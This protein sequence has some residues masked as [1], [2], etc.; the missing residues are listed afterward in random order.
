M[1]AGAEIQPR[2][3][4]QM[5]ATPMSS[6]SDPNTAT[7]GTGQTSNPYNA[8]TNPYIQAAQANTMGNLYGAR[9]AT[10]ANRIN[11]NTP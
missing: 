9:A 10:Q 2:M 6:M 4:G 8:S 1:G 3:S 7:L 5:A 11:Q